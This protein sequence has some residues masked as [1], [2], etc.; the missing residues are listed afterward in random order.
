MTPLL[1]K[2]INIRYAYH[3]IELSKEE[4]DKKMEELLEHNYNELNRIAKYL[5]K[6]GIKPSDS[7]EFLA[8]LAEKQ[9]TSSY[10]AWS[11]ALDEKA[12]HMKNKYNKPI[13]EETKK[14]IEDAVKKGLGVD[15]GT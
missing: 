7:P 5:E 10:T 14:E 2:T 1:Q 12:F 3:R 8:I 4:L 9:L 15:N 6:N 13:K 11:S